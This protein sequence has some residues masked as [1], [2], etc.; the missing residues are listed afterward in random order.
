MSIVSNVAMWPRTAPRRRPTDETQPAAAG[1]DDG[2]QRQVRTSVGPTLSAQED[3]SGERDAER[4][5]RERADLQDPVDGEKGLEAAGDARLTQLNEGADGPR[6]SLSRSSD[7]S[8]VGLYPLCSDLAALL[9]RDD[10]SD[11]GSGGAVGAHDARRV[12]S[13]SVLRSVI[14]RVYHQ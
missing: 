10:A 5:H 6:T 2:R 14:W 9:K 3:R 4:E 12:A 1:A 11:R 7:T 13:S 8:I